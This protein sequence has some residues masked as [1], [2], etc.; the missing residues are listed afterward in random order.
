MQTNRRAFTPA[1]AKTFDSPSE[2]NANH[3][4]RSL[5]CECKP[6]IDVF[7][8]RRWNGLGFKVRKGSK[9]VARIPVVYA[10]TKRDRYGTERT[11]K[12]RGTACVFCR[13]Q[14]EPK[15]ATWNPKRQAR[16][17]T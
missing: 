10:E 11:E 1:E 16:L 15:P 9:S 13:C 14:V 12:K 2:A 3:V 4:R 5:T 7:T 8:L 17:E 6:Y